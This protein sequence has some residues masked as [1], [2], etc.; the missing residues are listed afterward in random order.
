MKATK[1]LIS[2]ILITTLSSFLIKEN[3]VRIWTQQ[4]NVKKAIEFEKSI[5]EDIEFLKQNVSISKSSF[6]LVDQ[7]DLVNPIVVKREVDGELPV[8]G[9]YFFSKSDSIIR[10]ISYDWEI[11]K[12]GNYFKK[13]EIWKQEAKKI[14]KYNGKY[15][16][17]KSFLSKSFGEPT[18]EDSEPQVTK[19]QWG[20]ED[21]LSRKTEWETDKVYSSLSLVFASNTYRIR[22]NYY[23]KK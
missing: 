23:W 11:D 8:Y 13:Q 21:Y 10:F 4:T 15:N 18:I 16:Q 1:I 14:D 12:Y 6:P 20:K 9:Q 7:F 22:W 19:S 2:I 3:D 17:I 5:S